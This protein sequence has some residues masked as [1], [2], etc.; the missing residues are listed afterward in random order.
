[1]FYRNLVTALI[2]CAPAAAMASDGTA[3]VYA[4]KPKAQSY[5]ADGDYTQNPTDKPVMITRKN[6]GTYQVVIQSLGSVATGGNIQVSSYGNG[7]ATC[8]IAGWNAVGKDLQAN[9]R[10]FKGRRSADSP[11][12]L[13]FTPSRPKAGVRHAWAGKPKAKSYAAEKKYSANGDKD[14]TIRRV[15]QGRY[16]VTFADVAA[17]EAQGGNVQVTAY[18]KGS[19]FCKVNSWTASGTALDVNVD[20]YSGSALTDSQFTVLFTASK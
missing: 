9:V 2:V 5:T 12:T 1:M 17:P 13:L 4:N 18:G 7:P 6:T 20:C 10:C 14:I 3:F 8:K 15:R 11:F 16:K 19:A